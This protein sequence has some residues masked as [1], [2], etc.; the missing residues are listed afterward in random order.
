MFCG[1]DFGSSNSSIGLV[2]NSNIEIVPL[3]S[4]GSHL[5]PSAI[6]TVKS[7]LKI[8]EIDEAEVRKRIS[9]EKSSQLKR[10]KESIANKG[11]QARILSDMEIEKRVRSILRR[12]AFEQAKISMLN[13][14]LAN[15]MT[16]SQKRFYGNIAIEQHIFYPTEGDYIK[17]PK[18]F[19]GSELSKY[20][21]KFFESAITDLL[22]LMVRKASEFS[23]KKVTKAVLGRPVQ[24]HGNR[25]ESGN[26]QAIEIMESSA[27]NAGLSE[28]IFMYEPLA[29]ALDYEQ[30]LLEDMTV[31]VVDVGGGT[32][33]CT[34]VNIGPS[35]KNKLN[36]E[37]DIL[38]CAGDRVGGIDMD[39][40]LGWNRIMPH[41]GKDT[42]DLHQKAYEAISV[43]NIPLQ[44]SFYSNFI[45]PIHSS[46]RDIVF[47]RLYTVYKNN[48]TYRLAHSAELAKIALSNKETITLPLK[49]IDSQLQIEISRREFEDSISF[50]VSK[51][52]NVIREAVTSSSSRLQAVYLTGGAAASPIIKSAISNVIGYDVPI[53]TG[54]M[55]ES[56]TSGLTTF[57]KLHYGTRN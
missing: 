27:L 11:T 41:L 35:F 21:L 55:F 38:G 30:K 9:E 4:D 36:R 14:N 7:D 43:T 49:Y 28:V 52:S 1:I 8:A 17:S 10:E 42:K 56:V 23:E 32:T 16:S 25:G 6:Y 47:Q 34:V 53:I 31:L 3:E 39:V 44:Q 15:E 24:Y 37:N 40:G 20:H 13:R 26:N 5:L 18:V 12:E 50:S 46:Q 45:I 2:Q 29:A 33:D 19:L 48:L 54:D 57:A 51:I 22:S